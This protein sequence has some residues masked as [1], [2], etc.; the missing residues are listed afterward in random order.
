MLPAKLAG[1]A[2]STSTGTPPPPARRS[3]THCSIE[4]L[5]KHV[6]AVVH[7]IDL[8]RAELIDVATRHEL[9]AALY[10]YGV[11]VFRG[12][13]LTPEQQWAVYQM[14]DHKDYDGERYTTPDYTLQ[15]GD[16]SLLPGTGKHVEVLGTVEGARHN[17][18]YAGFAWH[19]DGMYF[20]QPPTLTFHVLC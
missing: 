20:E 5:G 2:T 4:P 7:G 16:W 15:G 8:T 3:R 13:P 6:G 17:P 14:F 9:A 19:S 12:T 10:E 11:I 1:A 18:L